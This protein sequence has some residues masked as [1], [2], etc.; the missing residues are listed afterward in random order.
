[1][2]PG[3]KL[4][5]LA[6]KLA[7]GLR[8][9]LHPY[10]VAQHRPS[11]S[12]GNSQLLGLPATSPAVD[13]SAEQYIARV[14]CFI[15]RYCNSDSNHVDRQSLSVL[16]T[17]LGRQGRTKTMMTLLTMASWISGSLSAEAIR[18]RTLSERRIE[19]HVSVTMKSSSCRCQTPSASSTS[20]KCKNMPESRFRV[21][22]MS[23]RSTKANIVVVSQPWGKL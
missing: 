9:S 12:A 5:C 8:W 6:C 16:Q 1:M 20:F 23:F 13:F 10:S 2:K 4:S 19:Q 21:L 14:A 17:Q 3:P 11:L 22:W 15:F 7:L 18:D